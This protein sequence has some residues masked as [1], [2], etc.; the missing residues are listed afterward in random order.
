[1]VREMKHTEIGDIPVDW[2]LQT[3][4]ETFRVLSN[5]TLSRENLNN[6]GGAVRNIHYG[7]ILTKFPEVLDYREE[8]IPYINDLSLL[9]SSTQLL[10]DG[11]IVI[12]DTAEDDAVGKVT[13]VQNIGNG[14]LVAG[15]HTIPCRVKKGEFAPGW[16]GY[17]M[18]SHLFHGQV[19]PFVTGI[20]VSSIS[21][22]AISETII[23]IPPIEE[24]KAIIR[25]LRDVDAYLYHSNNLVVKKLA[26]KNGMMQ[27]LLSGD[28]RVSG[29]TKPWEYKALG[30]FRE[31]TSTIRVHES[32]WRNNG[33]PFYRA[34][35]IVALHDNLAISPLHISEELYIQNT[36]K[37][38]EISEGDL[39]ITGV[40]TIGVPYAVEANDKFYFKDGNI[41]WAKKD[42]DSVGK[43]LFYQFDS[44][45]VRKQIDDMAGIGT[46]GTY[47]IEGAKKTVI[48]MPEY[49]E[50]KEIVDILNSISG[51]IIKLQSKIQKI[52]GIKSGMMSGLL[53]GKIR[54]V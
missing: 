50:Q 32:D 26:L 30:S 40:G 14:K 39:L 52:K 25:A 54:L 12:A 16:L 53:S 33:I 42:K 7:D 28:I 5:N 27:K 9:T 31:I 49:Q 3:F 2:E 10:Q 45:F 37:C 11:D 34:R 21:K 41:I 18:N 22:S 36:L 1:M 48:P 43:F 44:S 8:D 38:G 15:L 6:R 20:K 51:D 19:L 35:E 13:E 29:F 17:Y 46:V 4:E 24:Q 47:T 23:A